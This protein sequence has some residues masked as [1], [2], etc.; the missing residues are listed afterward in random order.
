[1]ASGNPDVWS[2]NLKTG[3]RTRLTSNADWDEDNAISPNGGTLALW[4][5]RTAHLIDMMGGLLPVRDFIDAPMVAA[6]A[7]LYI[8]SQ[9]H[10]RCLSG[11]EW[12][13]PA[14]GDRNATLAGQPIVDFS[15]P[16]VRV[17]DNLAGW[18]IW[19]QQS[20]MLALNTYV[21]PNGKP[22]EPFTL[23]ARHLLVAKFPARKPSAPQRVVSSAVGAWA[24]APADCHPALGYS[25]T[26]TLHGPGA[27]TVTVSYGGTRGAVGTG[28]L[29]ETYNH[30]SDDG[31]SFVTGTTT[32]ELLQSAIGKDREISHLKMTGRHTGS[33]N[34]DITIIGGAPNDQGG[35]PS[36]EGDAT[37]TYDGKTVTGPPAGLNSL[38]PCKNNGP[39]YEPKLKATAKRLGH[40]RYRV[41]VTA[42]IAGAGADEAAVNIEPVWHARIEVSGRKVFTNHNGIAIVTA[43]HAGRRFIVHVTD[44]DTLV[45]TSRSIG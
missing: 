19:N 43:P 11:P 31:K 7:N 10:L 27:G 14:G 26:V 15:D 8:N 22:L 30:Y 20:T 33:S 39:V 38:S 2:I 17:N 6:N 21:T 18:P 3:K 23:S 16:G 5:N 45:P 32:I 25:G 44:G 13:L 1:M 4:S 34:I 12:L 42:R 37:T 29:S 41:K 28:T 9:D 24:P 40:N 36:Y 35:Y